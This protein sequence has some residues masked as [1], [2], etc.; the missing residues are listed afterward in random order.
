[1][2]GYDFG[3]GKEIWSATGLGENTI[4]QPVQHGDIVFVMSGY[5]NPNLLAIRLGRSGDL[6][7][8][9]A[10]VWT[11]NRGLSYTPSPVLHDGILYLLTDTAQLSALDAAT[12]TPHYQQVRMEKAYNI[13]ASMVGADGRLYISTEE[14]DVVVVRMGP[15]FEVLA[16]NTLTDHSFIA[17]PAIVG[18]D[19]YL[20]S[21]THLFRI[22]GGSR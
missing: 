5:R 2:V 4:P 13:K 17:T 21:R 11:T 18:G 9:D 19:I 14:G 22:G 8:T 12:G 7:G 1:M 10:I 20:R 3:T 15:T 16:T 6:T